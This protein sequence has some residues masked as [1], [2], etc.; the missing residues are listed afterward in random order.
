MLLIKLLGEKPTGWT[1]MENI[2]Q[3]MARGMAWMV[4]AR[5]ADRSVGLLSTIILARLLVPGDFG[6]IAMATAIGA[7]LDLF[8]AFSFDVALIQKSQA[9]RRHYDTAWTLNLIFGVVCGLGMILLAIPAAGFYNEPRLT[10]VMY[11]LSISSFVIALN[12]IGIVDFRKELNFRQEFIFIFVRRILTF[13]VTIAMAIIFRSYWALLVGITLGRI[14]NCW[15]SYVMSNYRPRLSLA[16]WR[17][18]F[19]FSKWLFVNNLLHFLRNGG[20]TFVIGRMFGARELG[21]YRISYELSHLP[22]TE[23]VAP[24]N[25][26]AFPGYAKMKTPDEVRVSYLNLLG[27]ITLVILPIGVGIAAVAQPMVLTALGDQWVDAT[28][29]IGI[30]AISGAINA[31]QTNNTSV[32]LAMGHPHKITIFQTCYLAI[33]FPALYFS[34]KEYGIVGAGYAYLLAQVVDA[35]LQTALTKSLLHFSWSQIVKVAWRPAIGAFIMYAV[36]AAVDQ[37]IIQQAPWVR[38]LLDVLAGIAVYAVSILVLWLVSGRP[39]GSE[40]TVLSRLKLM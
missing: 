7:M 6:L 10:E 30:L 9:E 25:R 27:L 14:I 40:T 32:F 31:T 5:L 2:N 1:E 13:F 21:V 15:M 16:A 23:L 11:V 29:L 33:L 38:L 3:R 19:G 36:V 18:L 17:E 12:N 8:G 34:L 35:V 39:V 26:V 37:Q 24:I 20:I 22:S 4:A 28:A